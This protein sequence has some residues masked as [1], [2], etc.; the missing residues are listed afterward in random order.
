MAFGVARSKVSGQK[1]IHRAWMTCS[2]SL[3]VTDAAAQILD[4][5]DVIDIRRSWSPSRWN[6]TWFSAACHTFT[7]YEDCGSTHAMYTLVDSINI[8]RCSV[9]T[10]LDLM[11]G[12]RWR[13][14]RAL[15]AQV[16]DSAP[17][18]IPISIKCHSFVDCY[19]YFSAI[20]LD[21]VDPL[22]LRS[23]SWSLSTSISM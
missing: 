7:I 15:A 2:Q 12:R 4:Y 6:L 22:F 20:L 19:P 17:P 8:S 14:L 3:M 5:A 16:Q 9:L 1:C 21:V 18:C 10:W 13:S 11:P 23:S